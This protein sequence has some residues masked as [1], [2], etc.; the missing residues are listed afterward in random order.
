M[1]GQSTDVHK[2]PES[3]RKKAVAPTGTKGVVQGFTTG[4][5]G[6]QNTPGKKK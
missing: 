3:T 2:S 5:V 6:M 4:M 1:A